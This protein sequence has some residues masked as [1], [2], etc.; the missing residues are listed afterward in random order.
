MVRAPLEILQRACGSEEPTDAGEHGK[1]HQR[2]VSLS[3]R[4]ICAVICLT[5][6]QQVLAHLDS[7]IKDPA[8][9][10]STSYGAVPLFCSQ[11]TG[12]LSTI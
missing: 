2:A 3:S 7:I 11:V 1:H 4:Q 12:L 8:G 6:E 9:P 10:T 5:A